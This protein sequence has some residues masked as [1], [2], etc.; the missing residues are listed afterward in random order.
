MS[1]RDLAIVRKETVDIVAGRVREF[2]QNGELHLPPNYSPENAL[3][4]AWLILQETR[5]KNGKPVLETCTR[6]SVANSLLDMVV[7]GLN[8][9][10]RQCWFIAYGNRLVC[11]RSYFGDMAVVKRVLPQAEIWFGVVYE[12]DE[13]EFKLERGRKIIVKHEQKLEN[14]HPDKI[15]AAYCVIDPGNGGEPYTEIMT[16]EQIKRSWRQSQTYRE[17]GGN[18][19]HHTFTDQMCIRTVVRRACKYVVNASSDDYL[20]LHH[21]HRA[22]E[23][24]A[25]AEAEAAA[26]GAVIDV[27]PVVD[28][29]TAAQED[30]AAAPAEVPPEPA[31]EA[32]RAEPEAAARPVDARPAGTAAAGNGATPALAA[33]GAQQAQLKVGPGF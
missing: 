21:Y 10:K 30:G 18:T 31:A 19:P 1:S 8:P 4:A 29:S 16:I 22:D 12:G 5:D 6:E 26:N 14:V 20:L 2:I 27:E 11:Q 24:A 7:Q 32:Q 9:A 3:K 33:A 13:F 17:S 15:K 28:A 23:Q 25:E